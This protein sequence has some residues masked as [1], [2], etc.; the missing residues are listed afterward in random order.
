M[1]AN[2][3]LFIMSTLWQ[4]KRSTADKKPMLQQS[5]KDPIPRIEGDIST[6]FI[7]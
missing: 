7:S 3:S 6:V 4:P 5:N 1:I 2:R